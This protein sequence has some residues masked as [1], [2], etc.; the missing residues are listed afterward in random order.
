MKYALFLVALFASVFLF[1]EKASAAPLFSTKPVSIFGR[2]SEVEKAR[3]EV[4][5]KSIVV[6]KATQ[7]KEQIEQSVQK[8]I[9]DKQQLEESK[10]AIEAE[11]Q[12]IKTK[13]AEKN[14]RRVH[15]SR[16]ASDSSGNAY[17]GGNCTWY[18]K[19]KR[20]DIGNFWGNANTWYQ[21]AASQ[22]WNVGTR[23]KIGAIGA[24][25]EGF[26]GH[27]V[28]IEDVSPDNQTVTVSEMN[29]AGLGVV[30]SRTAPASSFN[31]IYELN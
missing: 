30:S 4:T 14:D 6:E 27:V 16:Y 18:V 23:P 9:E 28:Y 20:P 13:I 3:V 10:K 11:I 26:Y 17:A 7:E 29:Y 2:E 24:T 8:T 25:V 21:T 31:Y 22:G 5:K 15:I 1:A 12:V 19:S